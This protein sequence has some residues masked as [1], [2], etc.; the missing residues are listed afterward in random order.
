MTTQA[1]NV[2]FVDGTDSGKREELGRGLNKERGG[3]AGC[4]SVFTLEK[5]EWT[6]KAASRRDLE[7]IWD[8]KEPKSP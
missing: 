1:R 8:T 2:A 4:F 7:R 5:G 3:S 6:E